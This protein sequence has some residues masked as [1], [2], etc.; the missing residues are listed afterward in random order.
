[1]S[2]EAI[3]AAL[4]RDELSCGERLVAFSLASFADRDG[5]ARPGTPAA[6]RRAGL[7]RSWFLEA[8]EL[9]ERRGL[10]VVE[11]AA[12]GRG[13]ASTLWL[14]FA[15][16][17]PW[18]DGDIN[19]EL[20]EAVLS[21]SRAQGAARLLIAAAAAL[22]DELRVLEGVTTRQLCTGAGLSETTYRRARI[23]LLAS[24]ELMLRSG[25]GGRGK[26]NCWEITDPRACAGEAA[27]V[28]PRRVAPPPGQRPLLA[29]VSSAAA[30]AVP[31]RPGSEVDEV[32]S[33]SEDRLAQAVKG[34]GD[35]TLS[36]Q[37]RPVGDGVSRGK[38]AA[39]RTLPGENRPV[40]GGVLVRN[41]AAGRTLSRETP[42]ETPP[43]TPPPSARAGS[44]PQN[45]R[46]HPPNPPQGGGADSILVEETFVTERGRQR[47]RLVPVDLAVVRAR[48]AAGS[49]ADRVAW[50]QVRMVL[51]QTVGESTFEIW[52]EP[53]ELIAVDGSGV[54]IVSAPD[55]TVSWIRARFGRLLNRVA[56]GVGRALRIADEV[57]R[58][59]A[60]TLVSMASPLGG[61]PAV[62]SARAG[63]GGDLSSDPRP[64]RGGVRSSG[65]VA[66][67]SPDI[68]A[69]ARGCQSAHPPSSTEVPDQ[70]REASG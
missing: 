62:S 36:A 1:M 57:E 47:R 11:Q 40:S 18:W 8:R 2:R 23:A 16:A 53:L 32:D 28:G 44:E 66:G 22:A 9:L 48:L 33:R 51:L 20:F 70:A 17:G 46:T 5:R 29:K 64:T 3:A 69:D 49:E 25:N 27:P 39:G 37:N 61:A 7:K 52:L 12:T 13:R 6:A 26:A 58:R 63:C 24:G 15:E 34:G 42:P 50:E 4:A 59:A 65:S 10:V 60:E 21:Y 30:A 45:P 31:E 43:K 38:G 41:G 68:E 35:R 67:T 56:Q 19:A 14:P 54:L 55:A